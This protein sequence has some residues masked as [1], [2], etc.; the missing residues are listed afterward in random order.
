MMFYI[1]EWFEIQNKYDENLSRR[2][3]IDKQDSSNG[4]EDNIKD[5]IAL[6]QN[7]AELIDIETM[8]QQFCLSTHR[9]SFFLMRRG[10]YWHTWMLQSLSI[11]KKHY[12]MQC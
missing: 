12:D 7:N 11:T 3:K 1:N 4:S 8:L 10:E 6:I 9:K 5:I 2:E